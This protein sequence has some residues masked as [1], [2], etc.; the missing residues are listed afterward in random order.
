MNSGELITLFWPVAA[1]LFTVWEFIQLARRKPTMSQFIGRK[2]R[3][4]D[5]RGDKFN[6]WYWGAW[7]FLAFFGTVLL[8]LVFHWE[9]V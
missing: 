1:M 4:S 2:I 3:K 9:L 6:K 7:A 5:M 8:W